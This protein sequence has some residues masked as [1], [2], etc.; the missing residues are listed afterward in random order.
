MLSKFNYEF[1]IY[2]NDILYLGC[3]IGVS[4]LFEYGDIINK[5]KGLVVIV[6]K[7]TQDKLRLCEEIKCFTKHPVEI[8]HDWETLPYDKFSPSQ[9]IISNRLLV[10][11]KLLKIKKGGLIISINTLMQKICPKNFL[12]ENTLIVN[13]GDKISIDD[14]KKKLE[15]IGYSHV[16]QI[17]TYGEY[18]VRE[19]LIDLF[20]MGN[21]I[22]FRIIFF[23]NK[24]T[25]LYTL[26]INSQHI[27]KEVDNIILLPIHEF[28][29]NEKSIEN[30]CNQWK[31]HFKTYENFEYI[32]QQI[33]KKKKQV[34]IEYWYPF[35][36]SDSLSSIFD[37]LPKNTLF[38]LQKLMKIAQNFQKDIKQ[39][40]ENNNNLKS[41]LLYPDILWLSVD[42]LKEFL[43]KWP[44]IYFSNKKL[45]NKKNIINLNY[46]SLPN[47]K[48]QI[49]NK[50]SLEKLRLFIEQFNGKIIFFAKSKFSSQIIIELLAS[51]NVIV[52]LVNDY[53]DY[54]KNR[55]TIIICTGKY[56]FINKLDNIA[57]ICENDLFG[58]QN[59]DFYL[60]N[61]YK[62]N[63]NTYINDIDELYFNQ[64]V[65]HIE[66]GIGRYQGLITI[67]TNNIKADYI[68]VMYA[69]NVKLYVPILSLN[70]ISKYVSNSNKNITLNKLGSDNWIKAKQK[71]FKKTRDIAVELLD[72]Y[73]K[74]KLKVGFSY[75][76]KE[77]IYKKFCKNFSF[78]ITKDQKNAIN[79]VILDMC[80][81][82]P[83][84]RLICGDVGFGKTEV[85]MRA[86]FISVTNNK[87]VAILVPT[88]LLAQQHYDNFKKR[89]LDFSVKIEVLSRFKTIKEQQK[90]L[91]KISEGEI[92]ILIGTH[93]ILQKNIKWKN[94]GLLIIDEE[95]RF[96]V[97]HKVLINSMRSNIDVLT[98]TATPIPRTLDMAINEIRDLS[99]IFTPPVNRLSVKTF[100][101]QYNEKIIREAILHEISRGGKVYYLY[102]NVDYI[103]NVKIQLEKLVP[104]ANFLIAHGQM[105]EKKLKNV[106]IDFCNLCFNVLICTTIIETGIDI[107]TAN[108][109]IIERADN[110]G[111]AQLHQLRGRVGRS[112]YQGYAYLLIPNPKNMTMNAKKR[113]EVIS[114]FNELG[115]GFT[116]SMHDLEIRGSGELL[117]EEQSG[118]INTIGH[119]LYIKL[120]KNAIKSLKKGKEPSLIDLIS[121]QTELELHIS[122]IL[123]EKYIQNVNIRLSFYKRIAN[124]KS[125]YEINELRAELID[126]FGILPDES[127]YLFIFSKIKLKAKSLGIKRIE[128]CK[129]GGFI[130]FNKKN[131]INQKFLISLPL[132]NSNIYC[133]DGPFKIKFFYN[134][135]DKNK[136]I[137]FV[138]QLIDD[139]EKNKLN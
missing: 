81:T 82:T 111:L 63:I 22:A 28:I 87:Q 39:R 11:Y 95:H 17:S 96:G 139:F 59:I 137:N 122:S 52:K 98:L 108:T 48:V 76:I 25:I 70:L 7:K 26:N 112:H 16:I 109:I 40:Y 104:E 42:N 118:Q 9:E 46:L 113:I 91:L 115:S 35:F 135:I 100:V 133:L 79:S 10:L 103:E 32:Y 8:F 136:R 117:G 51:I 86:A 15:K 120:L 27:V 130:E 55:F 72:I 68:I 53:K 62:K 4:S 101:Y 58:E 36:Y 30:F 47:I 83:M 12:I 85:A 41:P 67:K 37:Y 3:L 49:E 77:N 124:I 80:K 97:R 138:K 74:R 13:K 38:I 6:V 129:N 123:S 45:I 107:P 128:A 65:V 14:F 33:N 89:F 114:S 90:I 131:N 34:G 126:R 134:L 60:N 106:M 132:N 93:K 105:R 57:V 94:L 54:L 88:T 24:I 1:P 116:I 64:A 84:D 125:E 50:K 121:Q 61:Y 99:V 2:N 110:F 127:E 102:N 92:N 31:K 44:R 21:T 75:K 119:T 20:P 5:H 71:A 19:T 69:D 56:G 66:H 78:E 23:K 18:I 43:N 73:A 29:I